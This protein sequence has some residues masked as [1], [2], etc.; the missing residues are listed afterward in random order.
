MQRFSLVCLILIAVVGSTEVKAQDP[1]FSQ[2]YAAPLYLNPAF[3]GS[4]GCGRAGLNYRNQ[5]PA[6]PA[7]FVTTAAY[8]D[9]F[10]EDYNSGVGLLI[11]ND[12]EGLAGLNSTSVTLNYAYQLNINEFVTIR[13]G[14]S[15]GYTFRDLDFSRL[16]FGD[17]FD[18]DG[19]VI[20]PLTSE[21]L[22]VGNTG[23]F[24]FGAGV[25]AYTQNFW[26][27]FAASHLTEP[28]QSLLEDGS[29]PLPRKFSVHAGY[30]I[31]LPKAV[32]SK[33]IIP[34]RR[35]RSITPTVQYKTQ[36]NFDQLDLG[37]YI[38][39][40]PI[41]FGLTYR[42][43]PVKSLEGFP[44]NESAIALI[45]FSSNGM[46]IGY[47]FDY[48]LSDLGISSGGAHEV[49]ISYNFC[50]RDPRKPPKNTRQI[51]CPKF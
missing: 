27:G 47:S 3:T 46:H 43:L 23:Y 25:L 12:R 30:K 5:W 15:A 8:V 14:I 44:N 33:G 4:T 13:P 34:K 29:S 10:F 26:I 35:E 24:D 37:V 17:Q 28:D 41:V 39:L 9:Y 20:N 38:T 18:A 42:G 48:T 16:T 22:N 19:N 2:F 51:P 50:L 40:E 36:G 32:Y 31:N 7:S 6:I 21:P 49:S 45:G 11:S 1:Q